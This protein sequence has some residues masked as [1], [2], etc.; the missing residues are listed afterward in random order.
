MNEV[1]CITIIWVVEGVEF[2]MMSGG[3]RKV[4]NNFCMASV[5][6]ENL[7]KSDVVDGNNVWVDEDVK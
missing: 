6:L 2:R 7:Q 4:Y 5:R 3:R 1:K